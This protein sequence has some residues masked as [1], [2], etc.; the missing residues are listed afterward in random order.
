MA[1][2]PLNPWVADFVRIE[3]ESVLAWTNR[4]KDKGYIKVGVFGLRMV[5]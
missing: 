4:K 3:I 5:S 2:R 1:R